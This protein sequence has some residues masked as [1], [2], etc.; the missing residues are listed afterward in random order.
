MKINILF[1]YRGPFNKGGMENVMINICKYIDK[2]LFHIDFLILD[3]AED[4]SSE[5]KYLETLG[6]KFYAITSRKDDF[7]LH[8]NE[9]DDFFN[10]HQYDIVHTHMDAIGDEALRIARKHNVRIRIAHSH[11]TDFVLVNNTGIIGFFHKKYMILEKYLLRYYANYYIACSTEA[12]EWLFGRKICHGPNY[13]MLNNFIELNNFIYDE[14]IRKVMRS[15]LHV[16]NKKVI[17]HVGQFRKQKNHQM[18]LKIFKLLHQRDNNY[19]LI[20]VGDGSERNSI[21]NY[22][23]DNELEETVSMLGARDD[24]NKLLQAADIF[25]FPSLFEGFGNALLEAQVSDLPCIISENIPTDAIV[26]EKVKTIN[27]NETPEFWA[28][29]LEKLLSESKQRK[30]RIQDFIERGFDERTQIKKLED[31]YKNAF[32]SNQ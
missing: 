23:R 1:V 14:N 12:G 2:E 16:E 24:V 3:K 10:S 22:I 30:N 18:I 9:L 4:N 20:L 17:I 26:I 29:C 25:L 15:E 13:L 31:F 5:K 21:E 27:L 11:N 28:D 6:C 19:H 7:L 8:I 32:E